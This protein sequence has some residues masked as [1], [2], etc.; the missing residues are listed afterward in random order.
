MINIST[1]MHQPGKITNPSRGE[2][3]AWSRELGSS[4]HVRQRD[5]FEFI[6]SR[7]C[8]TNGAHYRESAGMGPVVLK[9]AQ[10]A[11]AS[12]SSHPMNQYCA[13]LFSTPTHR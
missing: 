4:G 10:Q 12:Y 13:P 6:R 3:R 8:I 5:S 11:G 2:L 9:V 7:N 1:D